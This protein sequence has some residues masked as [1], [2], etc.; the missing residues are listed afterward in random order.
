[1]LELKI[2]L[3]RKGLDQ[4]TVARRLGVSKQYISDIFRGK[5]KALHIRQRMID[6]LGF[7]P[8]LVAW[9]PVKKKA[10]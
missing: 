3:L 1:M 10:A 5:R 2:F 8:A 7:D 9:E 4:P 6:E